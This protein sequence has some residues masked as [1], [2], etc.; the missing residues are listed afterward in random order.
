MAATAVRVT[1]LTKHLG[2]RRALAG[3]DL[4]VRAGEVYGLLGPNGAGKTTLLKI[5]SGLATP[6]SG[7]LELFGAPFERAALRA[8]GALVTEP[9]LWARY[10]AVEHLRMHARL[11]GVDPGAVPELLEAVG[12][13]AFA[14]RRVS[15]YSLGMRWRLGIAIALLARPRLLVLDEPTN[16]LDPVGMRDVRTLLRRLAADGV[17][18]LVSSHNLDQM[19]HTCDRVGVLADGRMRY[20]GALEGL[21]LDG[22]LEQGFFALLD[23]S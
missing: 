16:G 19:A 18:V 8:V 4:S 15:T 11:R 14:A 9:G 2:R 3:T 23:R 21:A 1:G 20:E 12:M 10:S 5:V 7:S 22:D 17:T 6:D 13:R